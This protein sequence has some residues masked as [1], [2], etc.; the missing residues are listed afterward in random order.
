MRVGSILYAIEKLSIDK[1]TDRTT[2]CLYSDLVGL[3]QT[4]LDG[5]VR[6]TT[7]YF[8]DILNIGGTK[9]DDLDSVIALYVN[10]EQVSRPFCLIDPRDHASLVTLNNRD[11][12]FK[13]DIV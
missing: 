12:C 4:F 2:V 13:N 5:A 1:G 11:I 7:Q 9:V 3:V 10:K 6:S 8:M